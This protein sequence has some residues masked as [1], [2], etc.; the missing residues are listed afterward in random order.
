M[1]ELTADLLRDA[2]QD[3]LVRPRSVFMSILSTFGSVAMS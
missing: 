2:G 1:W 3:G